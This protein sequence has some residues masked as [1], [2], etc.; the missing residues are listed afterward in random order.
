MALEITP[1]GFVVDT[2]SPQADT[3][4]SSLMENLPGY[5]LITAN[6]RL[7]A[8]QGAFIPDTDG[9]WPGQPAYVPNVDVYYAALSLLGFLQAQPVIRQSSSEGT[10]VAVDAPNWT[11]LAAYYRSMS[12]IVQAT[13]SGVLQRISIP[14]GPHVRRTDMRHGGGGYDNVDTDLG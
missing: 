11:A 1:E 6:M 13:A 5:A 2:A 14:E 12:V 10:S 9:V 3:D 8:L 4:L 7:V